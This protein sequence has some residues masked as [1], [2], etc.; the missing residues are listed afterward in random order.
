MNGIPDF[1]HLFRFKYVPS[2]LAEIKHSYDKSNDE[3]KKQILSEYTHIPTLVLDDLATETANA[4]VRERLNT[5][6]YYRDARRHKTIYTSNKDLDELSERL[7]E[8]ITSR[9]R[10]HCEVIHLT[11]P[12][13]RRF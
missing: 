2:L 7:D 10:Q 4:W 1:R 5:I 8:R 13:R 9:I 6:I 3:T 12:D 11:G